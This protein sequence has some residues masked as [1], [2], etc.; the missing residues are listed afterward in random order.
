MPNSDNATDYTVGR[1]IGFGASSIVYQ[2]EYHP[3]SGPPIPCALKVLDLDS[4]SRTAL[5]LLRRE[6]QL[7]SLSKHPNVLRVRGTWTDGHKLY[8]A[9]RLMRSGSVADVMRYAWPDGVEEDVAK[10][11][12]RQALQGLK[13]VHSLPFRGI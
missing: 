4:L 7:M 6:T 9:V 10:C 11:I 2:A 8:I 3:P 1:P 13:Y 5:H 12:L